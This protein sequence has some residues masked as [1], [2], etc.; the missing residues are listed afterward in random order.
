MILFSDSYV[1]KKQNKK[2]VAK[3]SSFALS[4]LKIVTPLKNSENI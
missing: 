1:I 3:I 4:I 2:A